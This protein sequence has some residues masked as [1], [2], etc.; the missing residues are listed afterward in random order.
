MAAASPSLAQGAGGVS[1]EQLDALSARE[2]LSDGTL[3]ASQLTDACLRQVSARE[4]Q[5]QAWAFIDPQHAMKQ[6]QMLDQ[7]R[8]SGRPL[9]PL[10]GLPVAI[11]DII[12]TRDMPTENGN[13]LDAGRRPEHDAWLVSRLRAA[14]A[15]IMGKTVTAECAYLAPGKT[16]NPYNPEH[17]PGG[18]SSGSA[19]AVA[20]NMV[21]LAIGTQTGGSVIRPASFCGVVGFKPSFGLVPR[22]GV[23]RASSRLDTL[24]VFARTVEDAALLADVLIGHDPADPDSLNMAAAQLQQVALSKPPVSPELA[25]V[26]TPA[27][28]SIEE[29]CAEGFAELTEVLGRHSDEIPLP[30][31]FAEGAVAHR[32]IMAVEMAH[33][34]R[35]YYD[36]GADRLAP[37]TRAIVEEGR[38]ITASDYMAALDWRETLYAGLEEIF[39]RYDAILTPATPGE[40]PHGLDTTGSAAFNVLWSLLGTPA[41]TLPL[42]SGANG[43]PIGV[44]LV[45]R[46]NDDGRLLRTARWLV[47]HISTLS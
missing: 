46:R 21:P 36:H 28:T 42:L 38:S 7:F 10:H 31:L 40:A 19:A 23:L 11:K 5:V 26:R 17:T 47:N 16:R 25:F 29:D 14:G 2:S 12:D 9:G 4:E 13:A 44:Q 43:L 1:P 15:V 41:V 8:Q 22:S 39:D 3:S 18:S 20:S 33:N 37:E 30:D 35:H 27:W 6:A 34:L 45:G 32:R 24:G